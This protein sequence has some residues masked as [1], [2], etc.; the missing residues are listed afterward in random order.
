MSIKSDE[1]K[2]IKILMKI[3]SILEELETWHNTT[4]KRLNKIEEVVKILPGGG[5]G[6]VSGLKG[7]LQ[8]RKNPGFFTG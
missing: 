4:E 3:N 6:G 2:I 5:I 8:N 1:L 7:D